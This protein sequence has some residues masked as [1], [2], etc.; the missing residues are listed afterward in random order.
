MPSLAWRMLRRKLVF[1][2]FSRRRKYLFHVLK[3]GLLMHE[4]SAGMI[5]GNGGE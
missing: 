3:S 5:N 4:N 2:R 1:L